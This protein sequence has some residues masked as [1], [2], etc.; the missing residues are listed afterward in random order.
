MLPGENDTWF[1]PLGGTGEIGMNLNLY[2]HNGQWLMIDC[3]I[4]FSQSSRSSPY[5]QMANPK[6][7]VEHR[8]SLI[9][10]IITHAHEDHIGAVPYLWKKFKCP[11]YT[12][13]F[14]GEILRRKLAEVGLLSEVPINIVEPQTKLKI[15]VFQVEWIGLTHSTP[16]TQALL[17]QTPK[18]N[19]FHT[20]D[21]KLDP[22]PVVGPTYPKERLKNLSN[23]KITAMVCDST[24]AMEEG[25]SISEGELGL[26]LLEL[27][28]NAPGK[29]V[30]SCFGSNI[31]RLHTIAS[32]AKKAGRYA[33]LLGRSLKNS[34]S[35]AK[36]AGIWSNE[37]NFVDSRDIDYISPKEILAVATGSQGEPR[38]AL[39]RLARGA[40]PDLS[41]TAGDTVIFSSRIIPGNEQSVENL[42]R[43]LQRTGIKIFEDNNLNR[44]IHASG[45]APAKELKTLYHWVQPKVAIPVHGEPQ[46]LKANASLAKEAGVPHQLV[47]LN[48]D[49]YTLTPNISVKRGAV[50]A[51]RLGLGKNSLVTVKQGAEV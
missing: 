8:D 36:A 38:A 43:R 24:N 34:Y 29:V 30:I 31:A 27:V 12:T 50:L 4:T 44:P 37:L 1:L 49:L 39:D 23:Q 41:L 25:S 28:E 51:G 15:G 45:H 2:G 42:T 11:I 9:S 48:G 10:L 21:W 47:G 14:T 20:A 7:I 19:I 40:H 6:F 32:V 16:E 46:H 5:I 13:A 26:G 17:I 35:A 3:G 22:N 33:C 18:A